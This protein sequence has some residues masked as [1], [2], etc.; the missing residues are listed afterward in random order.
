MKINDVTLSEQFYQ[1][2]DTAP[3]E[4]R[5]RFDS[6]LK[7]LLNQGEMINSFQAH[8]VKDVEEPFWIGYI[9]VGKR[10]WRVLFDFNARGVI[11]LR[12]LPHKAMDKLLSSKYIR[13]T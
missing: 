8:K 2:W 13:L 9:T 7:M 12:L 11:F 1:D 3:D 10:S 4:I 5:D 6:K